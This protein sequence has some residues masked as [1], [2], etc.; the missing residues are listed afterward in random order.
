MRVPIKL[1]GRVL[2]TGLFPRTNSFV[3]PAEDRVKILGHPLAL[4]RQASDE[5]GQ[6]VG[7]AVWGSQAS[8]VPQKTS[9]W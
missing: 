1:Y 2:G 9:E 6:E 3:N 5:Q 7:E 4:R 8:Q